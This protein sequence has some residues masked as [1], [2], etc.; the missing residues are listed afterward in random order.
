MRPRHFHV[1]LGP[2]SLMGKM[3]GQDSL[4]QMID[5]G[6]RCF[7]AEGGSRTHTTLRSTD[8]K[9]DSAAVT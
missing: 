2:G 4:A 8:F 5:T 9:P 1:I 7:G 3:T 6:E